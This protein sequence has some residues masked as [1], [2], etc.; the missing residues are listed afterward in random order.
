MEV[1]KLSRENLE[2]RVYELTSENTELKKQRLSQD[3]KM[4]RLATK[5][6][7]LKSDMK[8]LQVGKPTKYTN[9]L[10]IVEDLKMK[11]AKQEQ[12]ISS[13]K[14][15]LLLAKNATPEQNQNR[16]KSLKGYSFVEPRIDTGL[17]YKQGGVVT[18]GK[19]TPIRQKPPQF[20]Q[21]GQS[22]LNNAKLEIEQLDQIVDQ[23]KYQ[24][25]VVE[26]EKQD[27]LNRQQDLE[28]GYENKL[29]SLREQL[30]EQQR[31]GISEDIDIINLQRKIK[32]YEDQLGD[33]DTKVLK[34]RNELTVCKKERDRAEDEA[35]DLRTQVERLTA[36]LRASQNRAD[37][38]LLQSN[39]AHEL[40]IALEEVEREREI[41]KQ[42]NSRLIEDVFDIEKEKTYKQNER[43]LRDR[44]K[45]LEHRLERLQSTTQEALPEHDEIFDKYLIEKDRANELEHTVNKLELTNRELVIQLDRARELLEEEEKNRVRER[46]A[47][48]AE[49]QESVTRDTGPKE[50]TPSVSKMLQLEVESEV[51]EDPAAEMRELQAEHANLVMELEKTNMLLDIQYK[52]KQDYQDEVAALT[53]KYDRA[54]REFARREDETAKLLDVR[55]HKINKLELQLRDIAYGTKLVKIEPT[56]DSESP[57]DYNISLERGQNVLEIHIG[58]LFLSQ[59]TVLNPDEKIFVVLNFYHF[60]TVITKVTG[61][62]QP[63]FN[64]TSQNVV[65]VD[66]FFLKFL[67]TETA[68]VYLYTCNGVEFRC[69]GA[70]QLSFKEIVNQPSNSRVHGSLQ[71][72]GTSGETNGVVFANLEY[73]TRLKFPITHSLTLYK[74]KLKANTYLNSNTNQ[75]DKVAEGVQRDNYNEL[76]ITVLNCSQLK[77]PTQPS[78][79]VMYKFY[80]FEDHDTPII[81]SS[82]SPQYND[83]MTFPVTV[84]G[85]LHRYLTQ[86]T[87]H[88]YVFDDS[89]ELDSL[90][91]VVEVPLLPLAHGK[92]ISGVFE[93]SN[94]TLGGGAVGVMAVKMEWSM[95]YLPPSFLPDILT[96]DPADRGDRMYSCD[97]NTAQKLLPEHYEQ[98]SR[99]QD[100]ERRKEEIRRMED[101][102]RRDE[103]ASRRREEEQRLQEEELIKEQKK[104]SPFQHQVT[105]KIEEAG[106]REELTAETW[107]APRTEFLSF[108]SVE[109]Y[110]R[111][112][113]KSREISQESEG[114]TNSNI[115]LVQE[116]PKT[117]ISGSRSDDVPR[118]KVDVITCDQVTRD[119]F[120]NV[121]RAQ[122]VEVKAGVS[123]E[124]VSEEIE[125]EILTENSLSEQEI[126]QKAGAEGENGKEGSSTSVTQLAPDDKPQVS[127]IKKLE[128]SILDES[129][130]EDDVVLGTFEVTST[131]PVPQH[132]GEDAEAEQ[133]DTP[134][135][136]PTPFDT[137]FF[138]EEPS[139]DSLENLILPRGETAGADEDETLE[140]VT[141]RM[142]SSDEDEMVVMASRDMM[143]TRDM[144]RTAD[145]LDLGET[146]SSTPDPT[147]RPPPLVVI[148]HYLSFSPDAFFVVEGQ[149]EQVFVEYKLLNVD[150]A[151]T[152]TP[153]SVKVTPNTKL[154]FN[155][156]KTFYIERETED[157]RLL[158]DIVNN[159]AE[160]KITF[161]VVSDPGEDTD[162]ECSNLCRAS[163]DLPVTEDIIEEELPL[164]GDI[165]GETVGML[166]VTIETMSAIRALT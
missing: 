10:E 128:Q 87:C 126:S 147:P 50:P 161:T 58:K 59:D 105:F 115:S 83:I 40:S 14:Q 159:S 151:D 155:F 45:Q 28:L 9:D 41:L 102:K 94:R 15:K 7:R 20:P 19:K 113:R 79:Y 75:T 81:D 132:S 37:N 18:P 118:D 106:E 98:I 162:A 133:P 149:V 112:V 86:A 85:H 65:N 4:K 21:Y 121:T 52:L 109:E 12:E 142:M 2:D 34:V 80:T 77:S 72:I 103:A 38:S 55:N 24:L 143:N 64:T 62:M 49:E 100:E 47:R 139:E 51:G 29:L 114:S 23:L 30:L 39:Q 130:D 137:T 67:Q 135:V 104:E 136:Q 165:N 88:L 134:A 46:E 166:C 69:I 60:E 107:E 111:A 119:E 5:I 93:I 68:S 164:L 16:S 96:P 36:Q 154:N 8:K 82:N 78:P 48:L 150:P 156:R 57:A 160:K 127:R 97:V 76:K 11:I 145:S 158:K 71:L 6:L 17:P 99:E 27:L 138:E 153:G 35:S 120:D 22:M 61:G 157:W 84:D 117:M 101:L 95:S 13:L 108:R 25:Q 42:E 152:E 122:T 3:E 63:D 92:D 66:D 33:S 26:E 54:R 163:V 73:Y 125:E 91:G 123:E 144:S 148:I 32:D 43:K 146:V 56:S 140:Q 89:Q 110:E 53:A 31:T 141:E 70:C 129:T 44:I 74:E 124:E 90:L 1:S 116:A 131:T